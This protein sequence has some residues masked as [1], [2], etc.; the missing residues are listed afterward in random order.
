ML[1]LVAAVIPLYF[2]CEHCMH[3]ADPL[4]SLY[5][6]GIHGEHSAP[7]TPVKPCLQVQF[8]TVVLPPRDSEFDGQLPHDDSEIPTVSTENLPAA[9]SVHSLLPFVGLYLPAGHTEHSPPSGPV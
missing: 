6:P 8:I 4:T 9:Q 3:A 5:I 7:S 1:M 2:P